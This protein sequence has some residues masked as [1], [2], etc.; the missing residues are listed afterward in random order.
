MFVRWKSSKT[1]PINQW[2]LRRGGK[3]CGTPATCWCSRPVYSTANFQYWS[4]N[5]LQLE[6]VSGGT[7]FNDHPRTE[8]KLYIV[9]SSP[10]GAACCPWNGT[11]SAKD[12]QDPHGLTRAPEA[13]IEDCKT[14]KQSIAKTIDRHTEDSRFLKTS[15]HA[16][17]ASPWR[18][19]EETDDQSARM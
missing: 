16:T 19:S 9:A 1:I 3:S 4:K 5:T 10:A 15:C 8:G 11:V 18:G 12:K 14:R 7:W 17:S 13:K 6:T 2:K